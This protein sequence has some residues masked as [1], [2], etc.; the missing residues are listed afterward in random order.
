MS[1][2]LSALKGE[3]A[4]RAKSWSEAGAQLP[5]SVLM[6]VGTNNR[7]NN[8]A[9]KM[10]DELGQ[11]AIKYA[12]GATADWRYNE[13]GKTIKNALKSRDYNKA[14]DYVESEKK[15]IQNL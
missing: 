14:R 1:I 2:S 9:K 11:T 8:T 5:G 6:N 12:K 15:R 10:H 13:Q 7:I 3:I 4:K